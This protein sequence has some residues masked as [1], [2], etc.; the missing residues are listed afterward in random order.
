MSDSKLVDIAGEIRGETPRAVR[1]S[2]FSGPLITE[3]SR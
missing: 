1:T 3:W 2:R